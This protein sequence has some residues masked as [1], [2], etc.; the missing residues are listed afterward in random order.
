MRKKDLETEGIG[1][2]ENQR[3]EGGSQEGVALKALI[4]SME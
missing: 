1:E 3:S 2:E 4:K